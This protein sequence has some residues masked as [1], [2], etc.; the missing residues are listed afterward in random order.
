MARALMDA[1]GRALSIGTRGA[2]TE[3]ADCCAPGLVE[4]LKACPC[5][6]FDF[7][8]NPCAIAEEPC[9]FID[10]RST[11]DGR[12]GVD[13]IGYANTEVVIVRIGGICY[14]IG[15]QRFYDDGFD[16]PLSVPNDAIRHGGPGITIEWRENCVD[17]CAEVNV[18]PQYFELFECSGCQNLEAIRR[19]VCARA[20]QGMTVVEGGLC[21]DRSIAYTL[22]QIEAIPAGVQIVI[23]NNPTPLRVWTS[24]GSDARYLPA[25]SCCFVPQRG[26]CQPNDCLQGREW[27]PF[28]DDDRWFPVD[29]CCGTE[30]GLTYAVVFG[31]S[32]VQVQVVSPGDTITT[33]ITATVDSVTNVDGF[34]NVNLT[35]TT[36]AI[37]TGVGETYR[38][39]GPV[40]ITM[41]R[42]CCVSFDQ[43]GLPQ[44]ERFVAGTIPV[45][46]DQGA[47]YS[48]K[49]LIDPDPT[50][51]RRN[52]WN[53]SPWSSPFQ[54][55]FPDGG[56]N[57]T[58]NSTGNTASSRSCSRYSFAH[59]ETFTDG[60]GGSTSVYINLVV[61]SIPDQ[62]FPCSYR[63]PCGSFGWGSDLELDLP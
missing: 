51:A 14:R 12:T 8:D 16:G 46:G 40:T 47:Y 19:F 58:F 10:T 1:S 21:I 9:V 61:T 29:V 60:T 26:D 62:S 2:T 50:T 38:F 37:R 57:S 7:E 23:V 48:Q 30:D 52:A 45:P 55:S 6:P 33:T 18:G 25:P 22:A 63:G 31:F 41:Q 35:Q 15:G 11:V 13:L 54:L 3:C 34:I 44:M 32:R 24:G 43:P 59:T 42:R 4:F 56:P 49:E 5:V 53:T 39:T 27:N 17:G 28:G 36:V 20:A